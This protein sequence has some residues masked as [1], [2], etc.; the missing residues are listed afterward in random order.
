VSGDVTL[1]AGTYSIRVD[2]YQVRNMRDNIADTGCTLNASCVPNALLS[3]LLPLKP[4]VNPYPT[5][6]WTPTP[7]QAQPKTQCRPKLQSWS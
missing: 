6:T 2:Y 3:T 7:I 1:S 4:K 5:P